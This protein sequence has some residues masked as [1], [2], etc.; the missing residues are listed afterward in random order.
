MSSDPH[1]PSSHLEPTCRVPQRP[2]D[3]IPPAAETHPAK[4]DT[5]PSPPRPQPGEVIGD[6]QIL[7][8]LGAGGFATVYLARQMSLGRQVALKVS[9]NRGVEAQT[10]ARLEHDHIVHVFSEFVDPQRNLRVLAMQYVAG[11][12]LERIL[13]VLAR[14][15]PAT[16]SGQ[17]VL[18]AIDTLCPETGPL[19][20]AA[21]REREALAG[22]DYVEAVCWIGA[23]MAEALAHAHAQGVLHRDVKPA[24]ILFNRQGRPMLADFNVATNPSLEAGSAETLGGTLSYMPP[25]HLDALNPATA[26]AAS[27][28]D[29]RSDLYSLGVVLYQLLAGRLPF[30]PAPDSGPIWQILLD[31]AQQRREHP[32]SAPDDAVACPPV[33]KRVLRKCLDPDREQRFQTATELARALEGCVEWRRIE[34]AMPPAGS[35]TRLTQRHPFLVMAVLSLLPHLLGSLINIAYNTDRILGGLTAAQKDAFTSLVIAYNVLVYPICL[36]LCVAVVAPVFSA[37]RRL[38]RGEVL[39]DDE[40]AGVRRRALALPLWGMVLSAAGWLPGGVLF[41]LGLTWLAGPITWEAFAHF[42]V[43]FTISGLIAST[44]ALLGLQFVVF[45]V[46]YLQLWTDSRDLQRTAA[47]ELAAPEARLRLVQLATGLIPLVVAVV[48]MDVQ[49]G[50]AGSRLT[51]LVLPTLLGMLGFGVAML[52]STRIAQTVHAFFGVKA[53]RGG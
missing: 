14:C 24:N 4:F 12:T 25:E 53:H 47:L 31:L 50:D 9:A 2:S 6:F 18:E 29:Q 40:A 3:P 52:A 37:W 32:A 41:P 16:W 23:R 27:A 46:L 42:V 26:T 1:D 51:R 34:Q 17:A 49:T 11:T 30:D 44:Y 38:A 21:L 7:R 28:V 5:S 35:L 33:L 19:D 43:S 45:R 39:A 13:R 8:T 10:L 20:S 22:R 15:R 36:G 48:M